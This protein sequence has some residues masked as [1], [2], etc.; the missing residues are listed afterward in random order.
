MMEPAQ[1]CGGPHPLRLDGMMRWMRFTLRDVIKEFTIESVKMAHSYF[2]A[3]GLFRTWAEHSKNL[4][5]SAAA[6]TPLL[7]IDVDFISLAA[8]VDWQENAV[9]KTLKKA[10]SE[11]VTTASA[12]LRT[13]CV[14][15]AILR[16]P[17]V[18]VTKALQKEILENPARKNISKLVNEV[19]ALWLLA[20][21]VGEREREGMGEQR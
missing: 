7:P 17:Q 8:K 12:Q 6:S 16:N 1:K 4:L 18:L 9:K 13:S 10:W 14:A 5:A 21:K 19:Q 3:A 20:K 11:I 15:E 2:E